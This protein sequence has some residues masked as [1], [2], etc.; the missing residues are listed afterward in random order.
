[1]YKFTQ[2]EYKEVEQYDN[3][4]CKRAQDPDV[5]ETAVFY[6]IY[7]DEVLVSYF[8]V[9]EAPD[10][11]LYIRRGYVLPAYR[12]DSEVRK[13]SLSLLETAA[14]QSG[15]RHIEF[16]STRNPWAYTKM[17]KSLGYTP[18]YIGFRKTLEVKSHG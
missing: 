14:Q 18:R 10:D 17:F 3:D 1:M 13:V 12:A 8:A 15:Y 9:T 5:P 7:K 6:G 11:S 2:I 4:Y 16:E